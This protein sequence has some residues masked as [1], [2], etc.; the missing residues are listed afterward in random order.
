MSD[1]GVADP[2]PC[3]ASRFL[4]SQCMWGRAWALFSKT[5]F[6][7]FSNPKTLKTTFLRN[8]ARLGSPPRDLSRC[9][10]L[11]NVVFELFETRKKTKLRNLARL[12]SPPRDLS[13]CTFLK[14]VVFE[15]FE[16]RK[17]TKLRNL[18]RL[19]PPPR[20]SSRC[21]FLKNVVFDLFAPQKPKKYVFEKPGQTRFPPGE[22]ELV[23]FSKKTFLRNLARLDSARG[24]R[25]GALFSKMSLLSFSRPKTLKKTFL[26]IWPGS[27]PPGG[28]QPVHFS[29]KRH[30]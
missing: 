13:R 20:D 2:K 30:F 18:A 12:G 4:T 15:L 29:Q 25:A 22:L 7:S 5:S 1:F 11:K 9:T 16:T 10:F 28:L 23:H 27:I 24:T 26:R 14:N 19:G 8:L 21:T 6:L 3:R 17:K